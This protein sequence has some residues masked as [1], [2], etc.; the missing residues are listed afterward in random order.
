MEPPEAGLEQ[1]ILKQCSLKDM[2]LDH[3]IM[4]S[5]L[6]IGCLCSL[7][8][9]TTRWCLSVK[10][11]DGEQLTRPCTETG[12]IM[13]HVK[14]DPSLKW[15]VKIREQ[16]VTSK[17]KA[18]M[19]QVSS[20]RNIPHFSTMAKMVYRECSITCMNGTMVIRF[21]YGLPRTIS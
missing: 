11:G 15:V 9:A 20:I 4:G 1:V 3:G 16:E 12:M 2:P 8:S 19:K 5:N 13:I 7:E 18:I 6:T 17:I 10:V 21:S 14:E